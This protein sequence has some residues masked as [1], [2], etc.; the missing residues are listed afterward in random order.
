MHFTYHRRIQVPKKGGI[1]DLPLSVPWHR[2]WMRN[3]MMRLWNRFIAFHCHSSRKFRIRLASIEVANGD[4]FCIF[5]PPYSMTCIRLWF[6]N[7]QK[8]Q[9]YVNNLSIPYRMPLVGSKSVHKRAGNTWSKKYLK[10]M[11]FAPLI[12]PFTN[13]WKFFFF[14]NIDHVEAKRMPFEFWKLTGKN[15]RSQGGS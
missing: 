12:P 14:R 3:M 5:A 9:T 10:F 1:V 7:F 8:W 15:R 4:L 6:L 11:V 2:L 13:F